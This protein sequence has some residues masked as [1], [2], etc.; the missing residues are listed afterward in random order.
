MRT[1]LGALVACC[2]VAAA[3]AQTPP[4]PPPP[5]EM[6][7]EVEHI[8]ANV[9]RV[10]EACCVPESV[11][12]SGAPD[13]CNSQ[14][15]HVFLRC[16]LDPGR[17]ACRSACSDR[18]MLTPPSLVF[19]AFTISATATCR[20][21]SLAS[22]MSSTHLP[23]SARSGQPVLTLATQST[24]RCTGD[25]GCS[26]MNDVPDHKIVTQMCRKCPG[27]RSGHLLP[28]R[29]QA[30]PGLS[31]HSVVTPH[32]QFAAHHHIAGIF[33]NRNFGRRVARKN[34]RAKEKTTRRLTVPPW[35]FNT[36]QPGA[37]LR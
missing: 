21:S 12:T 6:T 8:E 11:C 4:P 16:V 19:A 33:I 18:S 9:L 37:H 35:L 14:C 10:N 20:L 27:H 1:Q 31:R 15:A 32:L 13:S 22:S 24:R 36:G 3:G 28:L 23:K 25:I 17:R 30:A 29:E 34:Y 26:L 5:D 2:L 7:C